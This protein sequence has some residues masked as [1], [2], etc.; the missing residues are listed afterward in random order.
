MGILKANVTPD[1]IA[2]APIDEPFAMINDKSHNKLTMKKALSIKEAAAD[3]FGIKIEQNTFAFYLNQLFERLNFLNNQ[4][5][6]L[7][8]EIIKYYETFDCFLHT[9]PGVG[10]IAAATIYRCRSCGS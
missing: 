9:I 8:A 7:D 10:I 4:I 2:N 3:T 6:Q 1:N 5:E